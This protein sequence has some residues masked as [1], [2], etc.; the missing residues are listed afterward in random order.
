MA[1]SGRGLRAVKPGEKRV[2]PK[3]LAQAANSNDRRALLVALQ[4]RVAAAVEDAST[5]P[6]ELAALARQLR[7]LSLEIEMIDEREAIE[8]ADERQATDEPWDLGKI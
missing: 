3:T 7:D 4:K 2:R 6:R 5:R 1:A 8:A